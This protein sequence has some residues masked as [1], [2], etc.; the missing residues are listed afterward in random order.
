MS[1]T[2]CATDIVGCPWAFAQ[3]L[4]RYARRQIAAPT[5]DFKAV[6]PRGVVAASDLFFG[7]R[8]LKN[9]V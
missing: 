3:P 4:E 9:S 5:A 2:L 1:V 7:K 8:A 6:K